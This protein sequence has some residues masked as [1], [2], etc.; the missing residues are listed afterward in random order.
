MITSVMFEPNH[1]FFLNTNNH[2]I[3]I[4]FDFDNDAF[5]HYGVMPLE[6]VLNIKLK[7]LVLG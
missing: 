1:I 4:K 7:I 6:N 5:Y 3:Q 2:Q